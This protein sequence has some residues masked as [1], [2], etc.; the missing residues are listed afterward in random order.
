MNYKKIYNDF[1][2][3]RLNKQEI[4]GYYE[5]H[6]IVP[7]SYGGSDDSENLIKLTAKDHFFAHELLAKIYKGKMIF[8]LNMMC[9]TRE[10][11]HKS[12]HIYEIFKKQISEEISKVNKNKI[13]RQE[14]RDKLSKIFKGRKHSEERKEINRQ[15]QIGKTMP[16]EVKEKISKALKGRKKP[17]GHGAK[18][19]E[20]NRN[21]VFTEEH[22]RNISESLK[23]KKI[24]EERI[25]RGIETRKAR[26]FVPQRVVECPYCKKNGGIVNMHRYHFENCKL[27]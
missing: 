9:R 16:D 23:G 1:I 27:K 8:A 17:E 7:K 14:T 4:N 19:A 12:K 22:R 6:H 3:D 11:T 20:I 26:G 25:K 5:V 24:P 15:S 21:R 18:I 13:V 2:S 10:V